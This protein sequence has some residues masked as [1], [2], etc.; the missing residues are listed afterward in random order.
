MMSSPRSALLGVLLLA[1]PV[2]GHSEGDIRLLIVMGGGTYESSVFRFFDSLEGIS[3]T[4]VMSD[5][6]A[7]ETDIRDRYDAILMYNLSRSLAEP[8]RANLVRFLENG[9]GLVVLHHALANYGDWEWWSRD[10]VGGRYLLDADGDQAASTYLQ[11]QSVIASPTRDHPV[12]A[13]LGGLP[14]H[15]YGE[16]YRGLWISEEAEVLLKTSLTTADGPLVWIGP[17]PASRVIAIQPGHGSSEFYNLGF[18]AIVTDAIR[19][20]AQAD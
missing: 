1:C 3:H 9:K 2:I 18:R 6:E 19:W 13:S 11:D 8:Q 10:V 12:V 7:F 14:M 4:L 15:F 16:T 5:A 20:V 17:H